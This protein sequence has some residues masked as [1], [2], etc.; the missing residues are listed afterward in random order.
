KPDS[1]E[2]VHDIIKDKPTDDGFI[3][4][5]YTRVQASNVWGRTRE[6][7][8]KRLKDALEKW[9]SFEEGE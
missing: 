1:I 8:F 6:E 3:C 2:L 4:G 5:F 7:A 9:G